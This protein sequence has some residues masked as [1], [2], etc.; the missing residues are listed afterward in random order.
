MIKN[1]KKKGEITTEQIVLIIVLI[2]SFAVILFFLIRLNLGKTTDQETC[3][4]SVVTRSSGVLPAD[5]I[6]LNCKTQYICIS[7][8]GSCEE[9]TSPQIEKAKTQ[10]E[11]YSILANQM[12]DCWWMFGEGKL[13]YVKDQLTGNLYCSICSQ[14]AFDNSLDMFENGEI[15]KKSFYEY[16]SKTN[17]SEEESY[18]EYLTGLNDINVLEQALKQDS[19]EFGV[20]PLNKQ[21]YVVMGIINKV[22]VVAWVGTGVVIGGGI[23]LAVVT[24]GASIPVSIAIIGGT[25]IGGTA[26]Y[27]AGTTFKGESGQEFLRPLL[28]EANSDK[29]TALKCTG[30][31]TLG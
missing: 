21:Q 7:K 8:D 22:G 26:G 30:I 24:A 23:A 18:L 13:D 1:K 20:M 27:F 2:V 10:E 17:Y 25:A 29:F 4:N 9:M 28:V 11:V 5:S 31:K 16:L 12:A 6:P 19:K 15:D 3:H 14:I